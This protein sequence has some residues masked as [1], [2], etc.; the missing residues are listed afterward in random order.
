MPA[1]VNE[2]F[3]EYARRMPRE[4]TLKLNEISSG[5]RSRSKSPTKAREDEGRRILAAIPGGNQVIALDVGGRS[6]STQ[7]LA[8]QMQKWMQ[9][10][11]NL[12]LLVGG[13]D[14]LSL[15]CLQRAEQ[16]WSLSDLTM[17]HTLVRVLLA[18]QLY[19]AWTVIS[20]HP[21]HRA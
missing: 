13:P 12:S 20:G 3:R 18:E 1:W 9:G 21:Y 6:W 17:P 16:R 7:M 4:C 19:R 5:Q 14:G 8:E 10:G 15:D 2:G 11:R